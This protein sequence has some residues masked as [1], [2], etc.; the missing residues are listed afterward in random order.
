MS[1]QVKR[2]ARYVAV[3]TAMLFAA[4]VAAASAFWPI[5]ESMSL[6]IVVATSLVMGSAIAIL[7]ARF[8]WPS[9]V[10]MLMTIA[11]F[12]LVGVAV[13]VPSEAEYGVVPTLDGL[14]HLL[15]AVAL[16]WKQLLTISLP[17]GSYQALLV[18]AFVLVLVSV[19][20]SASIA[21]RSTRPALAV[22]PPV[23][24]FLA[25][26]ALGPRDPDSPIIGPV[27]LVVVILLWMLWMRWYERRASIRL[28]VTASGGTHADA[29]GA[30]LRTVVGAVVIL[31]I[32]GA[33]GWGVSALADVSQ[34]RLVPRT[35]L[36]RPFDPRDYVSPLA[37]F[38]QYLQPDTATSVLFT[39]D[40]VPGDTLVRLATLDSYDGIVFS[41]GANDSRRWDAQQSAPTDRSTV[42]QKEHQ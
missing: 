15:S 18:P 19:V 24:V 16:G 10:V 40:G 29:S 13:A 41:V 1:V 31:A 3:T 30:G 20:V 39:I 36:E 21:I 14:V 26:S 6:V 22:V 32:A 7:G 17:V 27:A 4:T 5:Y 28:L 35:A 34:D 12:I 23:V 11:G 25:A 2:S 9:Y 38:R 37:G 42:P 33:T 8:S